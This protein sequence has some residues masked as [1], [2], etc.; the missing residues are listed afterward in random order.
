MADTEFFD[1]DDDDWTEISTGGSDGL[2]TTN[3]RG[4]VCV[5]AASAPSSDSKDGHM[6]AGSPDFIRYSLG[7]SQKIFAR[8]R[9]GQ[10]AV[11]VTPD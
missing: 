1:L 8:S 5:E 11:T 4:I 10:T 9:S 7:G 3:E 6:L 2:I